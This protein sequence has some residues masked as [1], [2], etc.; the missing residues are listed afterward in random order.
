[1]EEASE[2]HTGAEW[3]G[4]LS[5]YHGVVQLILGFLK[6]AD[7]RNSSHAGTLTTLCLLFE[8]DRKVKAV[9]STA[10]PSQERF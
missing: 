2:K 6:G 4:A 3:D 10:V 5:C 8:E 9:S 1:M 7:E